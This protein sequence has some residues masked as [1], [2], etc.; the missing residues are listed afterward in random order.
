MLEAFFGSCSLGDEGHKLPTLLVMFTGVDCTDTGT[1]AEPPA[2]T[3]CHLLM[4]AVQ[5]GRGLVVGWPKRTVTSLYPK[6]HIGPST[7]RSLS[8]R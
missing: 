7:R 2:A 1:R 4:D 6:A 8:P 5:V 3:P